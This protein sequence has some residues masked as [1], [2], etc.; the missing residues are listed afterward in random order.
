[1]ES[2]FYTVSDE[3]NLDF[4]EVEDI[5]QCFANVYDDFGRPDPD[6]NLDLYR[7]KLP[8]MLQK[9]CDS[10]MIQYIYCSVNILLFTDGVVEG[11]DIDQL[12]ENLKEKHRND[13]DVPLVE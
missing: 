9:V 6:T 12:L 2:T 5:A 11:N 13:P 7:E 3:N 1:M 8:E 10:L 4:P